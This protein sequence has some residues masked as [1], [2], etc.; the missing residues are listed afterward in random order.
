MSDRITF[1]SHI[2]SVVFKGLP[3]TKKRKKLPNFEKPFRKLTLRP[4]KAYV[5]FRGFVIVGGMGTGKTELVKAV[6]KMVQDHYGVENVNAILN[7]SGDLEAL[8]QAIDTKKVQL[9][10]CDDSMKELP[11]DLQ[12]KFTL[13]RHT[14]EDILREAGLPE[15]G[16]VICFWGTQD[17]FG[18]DNKVRRVSHGI[19]IKGSTVDDYVRREVGSRFGELA[20]KEL[21]RIDHQVLYKYNDRAMNR[22][23]VRL[24]GI[25]DT[26]MIS[27]EM[28]K[29]DPFTVIESLEESE[30]P[31]KVPSFLQK[32]TE[33]L[34]ENQ[35]SWER[36]D[37]IEDA[38][39]LE[40]IYDKISEALKGVKT[41]KYKP[42]HAEAW[43]AHYI[44]GISWDHIAES[45]GFL[46]TSTFL[47]SYN[48]GGWMSILSKEVLGYAVELALQER[49]YPECNVVGGNTPGQPDLLD[50]KTG[51]MVEVKMRKRIER[52][53]LKMLSQQELQNL[54]AGKPTQ[55][56]IVTYGAQSCEIHVWEPLFNPS[57]QGSETDGEQGENEPKKT[58]KTG[59]PG[60]SSHVRRPETKPKK[61]EEMGIEQLAEELEKGLN[62]LYLPAARALLEKTIKMANHAMQEVGGNPAEILKLSIDHTISETKKVAARGIYNPDTT[63]TIITLLERYKKRV[64]TL[65]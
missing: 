58:S 28:V 6:A 35:V 59:L 25:E 49:Y 4:I 65:A 21:D 13:I 17:Y 64:I 54:K 41:K 63:Q 14:H 23:I 30:K 11:K 60:Q 24:R 27:F 33:S 2:P 29:H 50:E 52:A 37:V 32:H 20:V 9:L 5:A 53:S 18:L 40:L 3:Y 8:L 44:E 43:K 1:G 16:L 39:F 55:V 36:V 26:G 34:E 51:L 46:S 48:S 42:R 31:A 56:V 22:S 57:P 47:N 62:P 10:F 45:L 7:K 38:D 15:V 12:H 61:T 19:I